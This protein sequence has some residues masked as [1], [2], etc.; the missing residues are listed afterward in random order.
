[1]ALHN[2]KK[3]LL[4]WPK[5]QKERV[6]DLPKVT[7]GPPFQCFPQRLPPYEWLSLCL[8]EITPTVLLFPS[9][10]PPS[11]GKGGHLW[12]DKQFLPFLSRPPPS[13]TEFLSCL[14][15]RLPKWPTSI[16]SHL[17][18]MR[19]NALF[20]NLLTVISRKLLNHLCLSVCILQV[21]IILASA[22]EGY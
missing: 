15:L 7:Q 5:L 22:F 4:G 12:A 8:C 19:P 14:T 2:I 16:A 18:A 21:R 6:K 11:W 17:L 9:N 3:F 10:I 20:S 1:M 13:L